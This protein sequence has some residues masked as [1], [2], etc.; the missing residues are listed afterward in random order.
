MKN[1]INLLLFFIPTCYLSAQKF[2]FK[3]GEINDSS[4]LIS[5]FPLFQR[6]AYY[7]L[8][9]DEYVNANK[10]K[11]FSDTLNLYV[12]LNLCS[13]YKYHKKILDLRSIN[14]ILIL[15]LQDTMRKG[16]KY[17]LKC[18]LKLNDK[19]VKL[20]AVNFILDSTNIL[21]SNLNK[22]S[23]VEFSRPQRISLPID[24]SDY[25]IKNRKTILDFTNNFQ[26]NN[27]IECCK[28]YDLETE[29]ISLGGEYLLYF[30]IAGHP[31]TLK[32]NKN[33]IGN[34][35]ISLDIDYIEITKM[36]D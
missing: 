7:N 20:N 18:R 23:G 8:N 25:Y 30:N 13:N 28:W 5:Y 33:P 15:K 29:F 27:D 6:G 12:R 9:N 4:N 36:N 16:E 11:E 17:K 1:T 32:F 10:L 2:D 35:D 31:T 26:V 21:P 24:T 19:N 3:V 34:D 22:L 14:T